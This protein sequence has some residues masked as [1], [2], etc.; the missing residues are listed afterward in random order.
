MSISQAERGQKEMFLTLSS[1]EFVEGLETLIRKSLLLPP[2]A[3]ES[4]GKHARDMK[5][6][7][8]TSTINSQLIFLTAMW[9][10]FPPVSLLNQPLGRL[11]K[12]KKKKRNRSEPLLETKIPAFQGRRML[13]YGK[14]TECHQLQEEE[15]C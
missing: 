13:W 1:L 3:G 2:E 15:F 11:K 9:L 7:V 14:G 6:P 4:C 8:L 5:A 12:K 10:L